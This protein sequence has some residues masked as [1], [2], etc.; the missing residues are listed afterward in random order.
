M[1]RLAQQTGGWRS[2]RGLRDLAEI[3]SRSRTWRVLAFTDIRSRYRRT[4]L[5]PF[6]ITLTAASMVLAIGLIYGQLLGQ[7]IAGY[8]PYLSTGLMV[9]YFIASALGEGC[10]ALIGAAPL[11]KSSN[12]PIAFHV[13]RAVQRNLIIFWHN[14]VVIVVLWLVLRWPIGLTALLSLVGL[15]LLYVFVAATALAAAMVCVRFRDVPPMINA[16]LQFLFFA[17]PIIWYPETLRYGRP[18]LDFNPITYFLTIV[19]DPLVG[20]PVALADWAIAVGCSLAALTVAV[21]IYA[22]YRKR[23]AYWL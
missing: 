1:P 11:V 9:W 22:R 14:L 4:M 18:V 13:M 20:R 21:A 17:S 15:A 16:G 12:L 6:W 2:D 23:I 10:N 3:V 8:L 5:G 19:R 7:S